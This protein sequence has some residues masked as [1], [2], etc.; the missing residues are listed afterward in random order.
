MSA[1]RFIAPRAEFQ[2]AGQGARR[3]P[4]VATGREMSRFAASKYSNL[5]NEAKTRVFRWKSSSG[6]EKPGLEAMRAVAKWYESGSK[7]AYFRDAQRYWRANRNRENKRY[8][9]VDASLPRLTP[10]D[11][12]LPNTSKMQNEPNARQATFDTPA[13]SQNMERRV[14]VQMH[15]RPQGK[16]R[17]WL[18]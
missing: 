18:S 9:A 4:N 3:L 13:P 17:S 7:L 15:D 1:P 11:V 12:G 5:Q 14:L 10:V 2:V 8:R 6:P 16:E